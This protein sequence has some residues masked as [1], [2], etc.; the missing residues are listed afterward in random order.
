MF[1]WF[2]L[3]IYW[4]MSQTYLLKWD[5]R[6]PLSWTGHIN[7]KMNTFR[8]KQILAFLS[9]FTSFLSKMFNFLFYIF[10]WWII[11]FI[12]NKCQEVFDVK[13]QND[14]LQFWST[15]PFDYLT[16]QCEK[17]NKLFLLSIHFQ[18]F[19]LPQLFWMH[20]TFNMK[21]KTLWLAYFDRYLT[22]Y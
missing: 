16:Y 4:P 2:L 19:D 20:F 7:L 22:S 13:V 18:I 17:R 10:D 11:V 5:Q 8:N 21:F 9:N 14:I 3:Q 1:T 6:Q 15:N 12:F